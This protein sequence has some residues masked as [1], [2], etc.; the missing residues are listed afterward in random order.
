MN[1]R[2]KIRPPRITA[3]TSRSNLPTQM[4]GS[5]RRSRSSFCSALPSLVSMDDPVAQIKAY[6]NDSM[7]AI[8]VLISHTSSNLSYRASLSVQQNEID[9]LFRAFHSQL[10]KLHGEASVLQHGHQTDE[11]SII[12]SV[13]SVAYPFLEK[14]IS[15]SEQINE[16]KSTGFVSIVEG[17]T[18]HFDIVFKAI[19]KIG[20]FPSKVASARENSR[21]VS[22]SMR[23]RANEIHAAIRKLISSEINEQQVK[24]VINGIREFSQ[25]FVNSLSNDFSVV[26]SNSEIDNLRN[27]I[28]AALNDVIQGVRGIL[29][30]ETDMSNIA[31]TMTSFENK[32]K[33]YLFQ[34]GVRFPNEET[35]QE[36]NKPVDF[37]ETMTIHQIIAAAESEFPKKVSPSDLM[38]RF[39]SLLKGKVS[40]LESNRNDQKPDERVINQ[41]KRKHEFQINQLED[42]IKQLNKALMNKNDDIQFLANNPSI[43]YLQEVTTMICGQG[44]EV[45]L[46]DP[47]FMD[48][49]RKGIENMKGAKNET[50][51][52]EK[53]DKIESNDVAKNSESKICITCETAKKVLS[54]LTKSD[55]DNLLLLV[56]SCKKLINQTNQEI[57]MN[58]EEIDSLNSKL[59]KLTDDINEI[60]KLFPNPPHELDEMCAFIK[61]SIQEERSAYKESI[62]KA[63][64]ECNEKMDKYSKSL[65]EKLVNLMGAP[66]GSQVDEQ[67]EFVAND[68]KKEAELLTKFQ[69]LS[70]NVEERLSHY[71]GES[72][73]DKPIIETIN[74]LLT[75]LENR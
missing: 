45:D 30:F 68:K 4:S 17:L 64:A 65:S 44:V 34:L 62:E 9:N 57:T 74:H 21:R 23:G 5:Q 46:A 42:Q 14:W 73:T 43:Q 63:E 6:F 60:V 15:F 61:K 38:L 33:A 13:K 41:L 11:T 10:S 58:N 31:S 59:N 53:S 67:I 71:L 19:D 24:Q 36:N 3:N 69:V 55:S 75:Q 22:N 50:E 56:D 25:G 18:N 40:E 54:S 52:N 49:I 48:K 70:R 51:N 7:E 29:N 28:L 20:Q 12:N 8:S 2:T 35:E 47:Y 72:L 26:M 1:E 37:D 66:P 16:I 27:E 32:L 39:F